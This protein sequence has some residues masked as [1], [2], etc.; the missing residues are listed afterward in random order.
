MD[1]GEFSG[2]RL[3]TG[4]MFDYRLRLWA[5]TSVSR[6]ISAISIVVRSWLLVDLCMQDY[7]SLCAAVTSFSTLVN[8]QTHT[9]THTRTVLSFCFCV[10]QNVHTEV[11]QSK[12][13]P[14]VIPKTRK[15]VVDHPLYSTSAPI[16]TLGHCCTTTLGKL[17]TPLC[18]CHQAV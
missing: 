6:A 12:H 1:V 9:L 13:F 10:R 3:C 18:L 5:L 7:K 4:L 15:A 2:C 17:F 14:G 8:I 11:P 16:R